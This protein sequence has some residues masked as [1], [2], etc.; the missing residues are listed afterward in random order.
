MTLRQLSFVLSVV[1]VPFA[2]SPALAS[3]RIHNET[4]HSFT[5]ESGNTSNQSV[6]AHTETSIN[7]GKVI[8]KSSDGKS[9]GGMCNEGDHVKV[10]EKDG[11][12][13]MVPER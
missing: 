5:V 12:V 7:P 10:I 3:C 13:M 2:A 6:S 9:F 4:N 1:A 11:V 8:A